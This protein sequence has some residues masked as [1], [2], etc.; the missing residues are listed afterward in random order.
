[1]DT[2]CACCAWKPWA[3][4]KSHLQKP[5]KP[6]WACY[7]AMAYH[8]GLLPH[9]DTLP[10]NKPSGGVQHAHCRIWG[11]SYSML[12]NEGYR[13]LSLASLGCTGCKR[14]TCTECPVVTMQSSQI[15]TDRVRWMTQCS[16][17]G[18]KAGL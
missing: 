15:G 9:M 8:T 7:S 12:Y 11:S 6:A 5:C 2:R 1:M 4:W 16:C 13:M 10:C 17:Y 3:R 14:R 18:A